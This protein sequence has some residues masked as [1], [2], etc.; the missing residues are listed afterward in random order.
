M[1]I[2][3]EAK[4]R[5]NEEKGGELCAMQNENGG[6]AR[7]SILSAYPWEFSVVDDAG[8]ET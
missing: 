1:T 3:R 7:E 8:P 2:V 6:N 5:L 4:L